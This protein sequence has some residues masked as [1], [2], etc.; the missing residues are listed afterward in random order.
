MILFPSEVD[1]IISSILNNCIPTNFPGIYKNKE[2]NLRPKLPFLFV[3][4]GPTKSGKTTFL[5][6]LSSFYN[7]IITATSRP[8]RENESEN[9]Y[10]WMIDKKLENEN[11][12]EY[13]NRLMKKY[14][15]LESNFFAGYIYGTPRKMV[16]DALY[17]GNCIIGLENAGA[18]AIR[19][20][21]ENKANIVILFV[22]P[23]GIHSIYNRTKESR[24]N[25]EERIEIAQ[26]EIA[27][28]PVIADYFI[29]N[30]ELKLYCK[31][32]QNPLE[33]LEETLLN[34][35]RDLIETTNQKAK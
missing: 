2:P 19:Y 8:R 29:H 4:I 21:F 5:N 20:E 13:Q 34:F 11:I 35:T 6:Y 30:S 31:E 16:T 33:Y 14:D 25:I 26:K 15:L 3:L 23:D 12:D 24:N 7:R 1:P 27:E 28:A 22:L 10:I 18:K 17:K 32:N 9:A